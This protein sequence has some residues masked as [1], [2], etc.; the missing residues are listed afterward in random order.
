VTVFLVRHAHAISRRAWDGEDDLR[1]LSAKG[2][3]QARGLVKQHGAE[4]ISRILS[5][6][7]VRCVDSV[8]PLAEALGVAVVPTPDLLEGAPTEQAVALTDEVAAQAGDSVLC[9]HGDLVPEVLRV[10]AARGATL[11]GGQ[12]WAKGST[13][14]LRWEDGRGVEGRYL[15][16]MEA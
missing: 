6:P 1:P 2:V 4:P 8:I 12:R 3:R 9:T 5:S 14:V 16:A 7:A 11:T 13:W 15:P 10:L